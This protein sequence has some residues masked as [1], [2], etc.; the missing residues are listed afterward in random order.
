MDYKRIIQL[1]VLSKISL[2]LP[3]CSQQVSHFPKV[4]RTHWWACFDDCSIVDRTAGHHPCW[5]DE[6]YGRFRH[7]LYRF[8]FNLISTKTPHYPKNL[9]ILV[10]VSVP[11]SIFSSMFFLLQQMNQF[12]SVIAL[13]NF[14]FPVINKKKKEKNKL[15]KC[16]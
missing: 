15:V 9:F 2:P 6:F 4:C 7:F 3:M 14:T 8:D 10:S 5:H 13:Y 11:T 1:Y 16:F 12:F